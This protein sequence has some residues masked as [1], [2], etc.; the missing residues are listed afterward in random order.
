MADLQEIGD[1]PEMQLAG[2]LK[3]ARELLREQVRDYVERQF[4]LHADESG[5]Q[6]KERNY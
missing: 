6:L 1:L 4:F 5:K 2:R 3:Q